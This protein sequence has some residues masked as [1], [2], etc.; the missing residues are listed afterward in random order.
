MQFKTYL[1][2]ACVV[3]ATLTACEKKAADNV[4]TI[5]DDKVFPESITSTKAGDLI[6]ASQGKGGVYRAKA[7]TDKA[8]LWIDPAKTG[9]SVLLG[10][11]A[12]DASNT[13]YACSLA[14]R[15]EGQP[16]QTEKNALHTFDLT[17]GEAKTVYPMPDAETA[18]CNDIDV[19]ADG[20][21]YITDTGN[22]QILSLKPGATALES[23][24]TDERLA[25]VDGIAINDSVMY[26]NSVAANRL[27]SIAMGADGAVGDITEL[28]PSMPLAR[29]DGMRSL[30][31]NKF[32]MTEN[33]AE[34]GRV[35]EVTVNGDAA[36]I[37]VLKVDPGV[38]AITKIGDKVWVANAKQAYMGNGPMKDKS[39]EPFTIYAIPASK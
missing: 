20:T 6:I 12:H 39:P 13:L 15:V 8:T 27:F 4:V 29:P 24:V 10:V 38:T 11:F 2:A 21:A 28:K 34:V 3:V 18:V 19:A 17:T 33:A 16:R 36:E 37:R 7:G 23:W 26:V 5:Q 25:G 22:A 1:T 35:T 9:I 30:G 32:L 31:G 14:P